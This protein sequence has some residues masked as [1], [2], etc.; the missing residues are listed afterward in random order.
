[1]ESG[2]A[3]AGPPAAPP[4][5]PGWVWALV[6]GLVLVLGV[7]VVLHLLGAAPTGH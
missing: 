4:K 5:T 3:A 6:G 1:M 2:N 7:F